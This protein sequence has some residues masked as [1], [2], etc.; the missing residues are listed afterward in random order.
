MALSSAVEPAAVK[1]A[2]DGDF[3][4]LCCLPQGSDSELRELLL[5]M[6]LMR[7]FSTPDVALLIQRQACSVTR[8]SCPVP[9]LT[10]R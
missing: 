5:V 10:R 3:Q 9:V 6:D 4:N 8:P 2:L 1:S 7:T